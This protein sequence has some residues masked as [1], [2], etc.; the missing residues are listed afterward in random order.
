M[1]AGKTGRRGEETC[2]AYPASVPLHRR[3]AQYPLAGEIGDRTGREGICPDRGYSGRGA[4]SLRDQPGAVYSP[5]AMCVR[6]RSSASAA[7][8]G[9]GAGVVASIHAYLADADKAKDSQFV[10]EDAHV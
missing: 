10:K 8:V 2:R 7:S 1:S 3:R 4:P 9:E 5:S 6:A